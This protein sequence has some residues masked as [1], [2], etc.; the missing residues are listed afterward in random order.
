[1]CLDGASHVA[2]HMDTTQACSFKMDKASRT[3]GD[4]PEGHPLCESLNISA[5]LSKSKQN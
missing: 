1:M 3:P 5:E 4:A 2:H